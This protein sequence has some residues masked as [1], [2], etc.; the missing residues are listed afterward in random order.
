VNGVDVVTGR[1]CN[2]GARGER[3]AVGFF[4][5][6]P[7]FVESGEK[8]R[9][10]VAACEV[11]RLRV[12]GAS[13]VPFIKPVDRYDAGMFS[14]GATKGGLLGDGFATCVKESS[15]EVGALR[16]TRYQPPAET[17]EN[18]LTVVFADAKK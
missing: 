14:E 2:D 17:V 8:K 16:P 13:M 10:V 3:F 6:T 5:V 15:T 18:A 4:G 11:V 7:V 9:I 1:R 12:D